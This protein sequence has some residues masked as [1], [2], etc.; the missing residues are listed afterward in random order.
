MIILLFA[1]NFVYRLFNQS[2]MIT[3]FPLDY[4][5]DWSSYIA[6][7]HFLTTCGFHHICPYW[8]GGFVTF[9]ITPPGWYLFTYPLTLFFD[10]ILLTVFLSLI[11]IYILA[12][13]FIYLFGKEHKFSLLTIITFFLIF[14]TNPISI[15]NHIRQGRVV[16]LFAFMLLIPLAHI[17]LH[18]KDKPITPS[19]FWIIPL[20]ALLIISHF[21]ETFLF[22]F[23][24]LSLLI[25]KPWKERKCIILAGIFSFILASFWVIPFLQNIFGKALFNYTQSVYLLIFTKEMILTNIISFI[26]PIVLF[27]TFYFYREQ[28]KQ[29]NNLLFYSPILVIAFF[30][31]TRLII[32]IPFLQNINPDSYILFFLFFSL[33]FFFSLHFSF[34]FYTMIQFGLIIAAILS[35]SI[36][37]LYT[38]LFFHYTSTEKDVLRA[39]DTVHG[40]FS[41]IHTPDGVTSYP[42]AY[43]GLAPTVYNLST[44]AGWSLLYFRTG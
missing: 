17:I 32:F 20:Y 34:K 7:L 23:L 1:G 4:I 26:L 2:A 29:K 8:Y 10:N 35:V 31:L 9:Q 38:P 40:K 19:F 27:I 36:S 5:N 43:Y 22:S 12:F 16:E 11:L 28:H 25:I 3:T 44:P 13:V 18:Y 6:Q 24:F 15:G 21:Q 33:Y 37:L 30:F 14:F 42:K 39:L 41:F